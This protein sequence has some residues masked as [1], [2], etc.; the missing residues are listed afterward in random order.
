L[1]ESLLTPPAALGEV[2]TLE[3]AAQ[4]WTL[5]WRGDGFAFDNELAPHEVAVAA[6]EIDSEVVSWRRYLPFVEQG[7]AAPPGTGRRSAG[8]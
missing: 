6:F 4:P 2:R 7:G 5:G 1:P 3:F 8:W